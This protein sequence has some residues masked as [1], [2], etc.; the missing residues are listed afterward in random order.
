MAMIF[1]KCFVTFGCQ[2]CLSELPRKLAGEN[3][4]YTS[5]SAII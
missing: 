1:L 4:I 2:S 3:F 5:K